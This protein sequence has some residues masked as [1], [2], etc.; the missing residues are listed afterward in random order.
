MGCQKKVVNFRMKRKRKKKT[1]ARGTHTL[2]AIAINDLVIYCKC[3]RNHRFIIILPNK[4]NKYLNSLGKLRMGIP[5]TSMTIPLSMRL[6]K[7]QGKVI[8]SRIH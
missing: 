2:I 1:K 7:I 4:M 5:V 8:A 6:M 3:F